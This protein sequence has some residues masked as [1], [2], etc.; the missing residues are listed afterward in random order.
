VPINWRFFTPKFVDIEPGLLQLFENVTGVRF[1]WDTVYMDT[2]YRH[3]QQTSSQQFYNKFATS[4]CQSP[5]SRHVKML[6]CGKFLSIGGVR[7]RC[8]C[9]GVCHM[10]YNVYNLLWACPLVVFIGGVHSQH[11][12]VVS[13]AGVHR[14][15]PC[16]GVWLGQLKKRPTVVVKLQIRTKKWLSKQRV[17]KLTLTRQNFWWQ[18][19][20]WRAWNTQYIALRW[21]RTT[22]RR[23]WCQ[24][25]PWRRL[26]EECCTSWTSF[27]SSS[28]HCNQKQHKY[29]S[30]CIMK[31]SAL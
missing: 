1:F 11:P 4:Q 6:G 12:L 27:R 13:V 28:T 19:K 8:P 23:R 22:W 14:Q 15:C 7:S 3:H 26:I 31:T 20:C 29:E 5:T 18:S 30:L 10:L 21:Q 16:S 9:S 17:K 24:N 25:Q 2:S